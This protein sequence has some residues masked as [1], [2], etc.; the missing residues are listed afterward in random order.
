[1]LPVVGSGEVV[2][3]YSELVAV[4]DIVIRIS[5]VLAARA[6]GNRG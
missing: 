5:A 6:A 1:M 3:M 2:G 4:L